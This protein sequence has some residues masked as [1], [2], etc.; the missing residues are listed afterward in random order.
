MPTTMAMRRIMVMGLETSATRS[1]FP[2]FL[3][4]QIA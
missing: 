1:L 4:V 2:G 3:L